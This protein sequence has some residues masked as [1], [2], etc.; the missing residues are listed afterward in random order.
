MSWPFVRQLIHHQVVTSTNDLAKQLAADRT[1]PLPLAVW[2]DRQT[3]GRGRGSHTWWSDSGSLTFSVLLDP[4][5]HGLR[6]EHEPRL[7]LAAA[8]AIVDAVEAICGVTNLG[9]RWPNDLE[10]SG[11]KLGGILPERIDSVDGPRIVIGIGLNVA[12]QLADAPRDVQRLGIALSALAPSYG[13]LRDRAFVLKSVLK[14]FGSALKRLA[15]DDPTLSDRWARLDTLLGQSI[16]V[17]LGD[18]IVSGI[19]QG[20]DVDGA[21]VLAQGQGEPLRL[22]GGQVL[23]H[24][25]R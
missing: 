12:S 5:A 11:R 18:R 25:D 8:V 24:K 19:A 17:L 21:L 6:V 16:Q 2:A 4:R 22:F 1:V 9:I 23:R 15:T 7:A 14:H 3:Q 13:G 10:T 20:I